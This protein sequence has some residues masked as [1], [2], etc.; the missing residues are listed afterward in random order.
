MGHSGIL[1]SRQLQCR[2]RS[3]ATHARSHHYS[4]DRRRRRELF[5]SGMAGTRLLAV[6]LPNT[7]LLTC[8]SATLGSGATASVGNFSQRVPVLVGSVSRRSTQ[9]VKW[10]AEVVLTSQPLVH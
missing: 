10:S 5:R 1:P 8:N 9:Q 7:H 2:P 3:P 6:M 4:T